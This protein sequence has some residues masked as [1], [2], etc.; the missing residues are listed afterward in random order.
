ML[1]AIAV[2]RSILRREEQEN[3]GKEVISLSG[4]FC[5]NS[6]HPPGHGALPLHSPPSLTTQQLTTQTPFQTSVF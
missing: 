5:P 2:E 1:W 4:I 3:R 6:N